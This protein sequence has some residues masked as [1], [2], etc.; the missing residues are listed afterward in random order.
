MTAIQT[1]LKMFG[2]CSSVI[3]DNATRFTSLTGIEFDATGQVVGGS[4]QVCHAVNPLLAVPS[5][6]AR[7]R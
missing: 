1:L 4:V 2:S 7:S 5:N 3:H 6:P